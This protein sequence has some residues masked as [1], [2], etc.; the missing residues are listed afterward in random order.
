MKQQNE[1]YRHSLFLDGRSV[2]ESSTN[3]SHRAS[4]PAQN[5][6]TV[7]TRVWTSRTV[8]L[9]L[10]GAAAR[11]EDAKRTED[12]THSEDAIRTERTLYAQRGRYTHRE[13][14]ICTE[15]TLYAERM[16]RTE[17]DTRR[18]CYA[19]S[20]GVFEGFVYRACSNKKTVP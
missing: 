7:A 11:T 2:A 20:S 4:P 6:K 16:I 17:D 1:Q 15:R 5:L 3:I 9:T 12:A 10:D 13:D 8:G 18:G 14:A 19:L